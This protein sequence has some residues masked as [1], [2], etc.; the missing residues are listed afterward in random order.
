MKLGVFLDRGRI[1]VQFIVQNAV[2]DRFSLQFCDHVEFDTIADLIDHYMTHYI[3]D[4]Q[5]GVVTRVKLAKPVYRQVMALSYLAGV[6]LKK[7]RIPLPPQ[8]AEL[9]R[10]RPHYF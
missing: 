5:M 3:Y 4:Y 1:F 9:L 10:D 7:H 8:V 2:T 6:V